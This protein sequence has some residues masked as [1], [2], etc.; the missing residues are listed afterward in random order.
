MG[1][2]NVNLKIIK[3]YCV[4]HREIL[5]SKHFSPVHIKILEPIIKYTN[6][7]KFNDQCE[8]LFPIFCDNKTSDHV[9]LCF[10]I[11]MSW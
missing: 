9:T 10:R 11:V 8:N 7:I 3:M 4:I 6:D 2:E 5:F 1:K